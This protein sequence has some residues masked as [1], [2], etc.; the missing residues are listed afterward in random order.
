MDAMRIKPETEMPTREMNAATQSGETAAIQAG[1]KGNMPTREMNAGFQ[2]TDTAPSGQ[3]QDSG[4][5]SLEMDQRDQVN[6][7]PGG[8]RHEQEKLAA[9][10]RERQGVTASTQPAQAGEMPTTGMSEGA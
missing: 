7:V 6:L 1:E 9:Y 3:A 8:S 5:L 10:L 4:M 2:P